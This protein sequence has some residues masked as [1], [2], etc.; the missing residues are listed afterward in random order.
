[1]APLQKKFEIKENKKLN[2]TTFKIVFNAPEI[3]SIAKAG[4]F[5]NILCENRT[6]RRPISICETEPDKGLVKIVFDVRGEGTAWLSKQKSGK[7]IDILGPLGNGFPCEKGN[8]AL[9]IGGGLGVPP[10]LETTKFFG[11][12]ADAI[13]GFKCKENLIL[14]ENFKQICENTYLTS[15]DGSCGTRGLVTDVMQDL[16]KTKDYDIVYACG[17]EAML[18][19]VAKI[20]SENKLA[21]FVSLE[22]RM[23]CGI[24]ACLV[25]ACAVKV[26][27]EVDYK[28]VCKD[29]PVFNARE[30]AW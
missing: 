18:K 24:G 19:S 17:P 9:L 15:D 20:C 14:L 4:Q 12:K 27:G 23:G 2:E 7:K 28:H 22:E 6:L 13:L 29:G 10:L 21:C 25:C 11:K 30:V 26:N 3:A 1:M 16:I 8:R 5:V